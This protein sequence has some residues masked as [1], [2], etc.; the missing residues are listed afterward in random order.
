[1][2][3]NLAWIIGPT[4]GGFVAARSFFALFVMDAM[5]SCLV[6]VLFYVLSAILTR[7]PALDTSP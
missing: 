5:I 3:G 1:M 4:I 2:V 6:A 7:R